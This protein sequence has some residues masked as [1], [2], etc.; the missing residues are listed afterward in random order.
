MTETMATPTA[1]WIDVC[2]VDDLEPDAGVCALVAGRQVAIFYIPKLG[3]V[4]AIDN[5]DPFSHANVL[6]RGLTGDIGG[7]PVVASPVYK[8]HFSLRTG[9][10]MEDEKIIVPTYAVRIHQDRVQ[11]QLTEQGDDA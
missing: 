5:Y 6:S 1:T 9:R 4:F 8:Q 3:A 10:C 2:S 11:I 7:E